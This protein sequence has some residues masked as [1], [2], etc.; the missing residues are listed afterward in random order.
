MTK[1][2]NTGST[3]L[4]R[5]HIWA[6]DFIIPLL[7]GIVGVAGS[8]GGVFIAGWNSAR[9]AE[10]QKLIE[11]QGKFFDQ[12]L[13]L[14][15]RTARVFG[16]SPGLQDFWTLYVKELRSNSDSSKLPADLIDKLTEAQGE[17][18]SVLFLSRAYFGPKTQAAIAELSDAE[19]PWWQKPKAKQDALIVAMLSETGYGLSAISTLAEQAP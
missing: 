10:T 11:L 16:K 19:G 14:I 6:R 7:V 9:Q 17:F 13:A 18:Q 8:L 2:T 12:R 3:N 5:R 1:P 4:Q 15:D